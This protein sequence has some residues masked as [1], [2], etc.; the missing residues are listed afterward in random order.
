MVR[1]SHRFLRQYAGAPSE[2]RKAFDKQVR[3]LLENLNHPS[4]RAKKYDEALDVWQAR[5]NRN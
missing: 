3:L 4:L 1:Y 2:V 5:V